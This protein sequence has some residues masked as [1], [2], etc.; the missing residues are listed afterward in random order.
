MEALPVELSVLSQFY[1][2]QQCK[3]D[4]KCLLHRQKKIFF[5]L[6]WLLHYC[7]CSAHLLIPHP[8]PLMLRG[9]LWSCAQATRSLATICRFVDS[10]DQPQGFAVLEKRLARQSEMTRLRDYSLDPASYCKNARIN[11]ANWCSWWKI[12]WQEHRPYS[13]LLRCCALEVCHRFH[14]R[15]CQHAVCFLFLPFLRLFH[16]FYHRLDVRRPLHFLAPLR[17]QRPG[18]SRTRFA[19]F[20]LYAYCYSCQWNVPNKC[21]KYVPIFVRFTSASHIWNWWFYC[22]LSWHPRSCNPKSWSTL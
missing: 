22:F 6:P 7:N 11:I 12:T 5:G 3:K 20:L 15:V 18:R 2:V 21:T 4:Q 14:C 9:F 10:T 17:G 13:Q 16:V 19:P 1:F 8:S